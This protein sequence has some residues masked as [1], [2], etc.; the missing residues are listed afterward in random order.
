VAGSK[1]RISVEERVAS[2][3]Q[4]ETGPVSIGVAVPINYADPGAPWLQKSRSSI[5]R[6][7]G[8][9]SERYQSLFSA[10]HSRASSKPTVAKRI[11]LLASARVR[12]QLSAIRVML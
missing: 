6:A 12:R 4:K 1:G 5:D 8:R 10:N 9:L 11:P 7:S 2:G 3:L